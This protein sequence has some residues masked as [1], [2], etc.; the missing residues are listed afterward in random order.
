MGIVGLK[1][2][3]RAVFLDRDGVLNRTYLHGDGK[4]HP[5][6]SPEETEI[7]PE[8]HEAC[9][10]LRRAGYLL[11]GVT[12]QPDVARGTQKMEVVEA[13]NEK[14]LRRLS[15]HEILVCYHDNPDNCPCRKPKPGLILAASNSW[16]IDLAQSFMVGDRWTDIDAG[17]RAGCKTIFIGASPWLEVDRRKPNFQ[18]GSLLEAVNWILKEQ[19]QS[20]REKEKAYLP[21]VAGFSKGEKI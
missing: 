11:I 8:V 17:A 2:L 1:P 15:L 3:R 21:R 18:A 20:P 16:R 13:I 7:L 4:T 12:N 10:A 5:P 9:R 14:L 6:A 19:P